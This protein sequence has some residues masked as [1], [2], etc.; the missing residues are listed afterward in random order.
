MSLSSQEC[1]NL[2]CQAGTPIQLPKGHRFTIEDHGTHYLY[3]LKDGVCGLVRY[4]ASGKEIIYYYF[5]NGDVPGIARYNLLYHKQD[6][7][8]SHEIQYSLVAKTPC[9]VSKL[10]FTKAHELARQYPEVE[11][12]LNFSFSNYYFSILDHL[13][14]SKETA[15]AT[16]LY[17]LLLQLALPDPE[18]YRIHKH[19]TYTELAKYLGVHYVTV[20]R[21]MAELKQMGI[22][23]KRG[24]ET[25]ISDREAL[26]AL[27][28]GE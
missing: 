28:Q 14:S 21:E 23:A 16:R 22:I 9:T 13:H 18:G 3:C 6:R 4:T 10:S 17:R 24:H 12:Y 5:Q 7:A 8:I 1:F 26:V 20:S 19:F 15:T 2:L 25:V 11:S 27:A